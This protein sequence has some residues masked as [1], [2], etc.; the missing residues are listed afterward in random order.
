VPERSTEATEKA[1]AGLHRGGQA[2]PKKLAEG[3]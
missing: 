1:V 3:Q 2:Q